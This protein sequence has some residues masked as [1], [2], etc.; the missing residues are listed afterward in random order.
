MTTASIAPPNSVILV[1]DPD[2]GEIPQT[3]GNQVV[4]AT[5]SCIA[6]GCRSE[7]DGPTEI[8]LESATEVKP[9]NVDL[10]FDGE[11]STPNRTLSICTV[12]NEDIMAVAVDGAKTRIRVYVDDPTE[13]IRVIVHFGG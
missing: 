1:M 12:M 13:P 9:S 8:I 6:I 5:E 3:M 7:D 11:L 10:V 2:T 4:S